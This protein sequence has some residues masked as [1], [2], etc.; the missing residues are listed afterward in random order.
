MMSNSNVTL[1][2][3]DESLGFFSML[4]QYKPQAKDSDKAVMLE[5]YNG[6]EIFYQTTKG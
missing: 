3:W 2:I 1:S 6:N 5:L 4:G